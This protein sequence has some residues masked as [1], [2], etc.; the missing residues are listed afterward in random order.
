MVDLVLSSGLFAFSRHVGVIEALERREIQPEAVVGTSS[1]A[2]VA[3]LWLAGMKPAELCRTLCA[4]RPVRWLVP[5]ARPWQGAF[6]TR[7]IAQEL[8]RH[9]PPSFEDLP[10]SLAVGVASTA[11]EHRLIDRGP[12]VDAGVASLARPRLFAPVLRAGQPAVDGGTVDRRALQ[13]AVQRRPGRRVILHE[14]ER[15]HGRPPEGAER[16]L[17]HIQ[18]EPSAATL[19]GTGPY[20]FEKERARTVALAALHS[21]V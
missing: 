11:G 4:V 9:L 1:G 14:V 6:S 2:L 19:L 15:P 20:Y 10:R 21:L 3:A 17:V 12:L 7:R 18:T 16:P 5:N 13:A 8:G